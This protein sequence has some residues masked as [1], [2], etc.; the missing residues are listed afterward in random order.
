MKSLIFLS[1]YIV[2]GAAGWA[3][4][5]YTLADNGA[6]TMDIAAIVPTQLMTKSSDASSLHR[7]RDEHGKWHYGDA[8]PK[9]L[10]AKL[11]AQAVGYIDELNALKSLPSVANE[12]AKL[13]RL[14]GK[15]AVQPVANEGWLQKATGGVRD[16]LPGNS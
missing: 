8:R 3:V 6:A 14:N 11:Q 12:M 4:Y 16:L 9:D 7:W 13:D 15:N 1:L 2:A 10:D 5:H